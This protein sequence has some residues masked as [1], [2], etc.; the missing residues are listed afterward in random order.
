MVATC[1]V[2]AGAAL[3]R[4]GRQALACVARESTQRAL[5]LLWP[6]PNVADWSDWSGSEV[7]FELV[8]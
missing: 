5:S 8:R 7:L 6:V 3:F 2:A 1:M 4:S